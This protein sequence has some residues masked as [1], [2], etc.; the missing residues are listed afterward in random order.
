MKLDKMYVV[1]LPTDCHEDSRSIC[2][3]LEGSIIYFDIVE[4]FSA[5]TIC[6]EIQK[7]YEIK[8]VEVEPMDDFM[9]RV[10][11]ECFNPDN[12]FMSYVSAQVATPK[13]KT[14]KGNALLENESDEFLDWLDKCPVQ[15]DLMRQYEESLI[16]R[17]DKDGVGNGK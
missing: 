3:D 14:P 13:P 4:V 6:K 15:W 10:N 1:L 9:E 2:G 5:L 7:E 8:G 11:N 16:Y 12:Y 17:F